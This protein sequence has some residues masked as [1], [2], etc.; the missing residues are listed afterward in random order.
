MQKCCFEQR[1]GGEQAEDSKRA[2]SEKFV[3]KTEGEHITDR[4]CDEE[5][6]SKGGKFPHLHRGQQP[7]SP[8]K[9][10]S[11]QNS[12][13]DAGTWK[14]L[15]NAGEIGFEEAGQTDQNQKRAR[16]YAGD[17]QRR[18]VNHSAVV[19]KRASGL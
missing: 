16:R 1:F 7:E 8:G 9:I 18:M 15:R 11:E 3:E 10:H 19:V 13:G 4:Q 12:A 5:R 6:F 2:H 14:S 17:L